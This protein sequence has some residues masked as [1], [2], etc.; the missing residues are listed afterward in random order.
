[1]DE[2]RTYLYKWYDRFDL[3]SKDY[4]F[5]QTAGLKIPNPSALSRLANEVNFGGIFDHSADD[6]TPAYLS[7]EAARLVV[8]AQ[9]FA[10]G[11]GKSASA[12]IG[13]EKIEPPYSADAILLRGLTI[14]LTGSSLLDTLL[15]NLC[16]DDPREDDLPAWEL[17]APHKLR[18][19]Q[20]NGKRMSISARGIIDRYTWQSRLMRIL[21][22]QEESKVFVKEVFFTQG[23]EADKSPHDPMKAYTRSEKEGFVP[24]SLSMF[25]ASW[26]DAHSILST[27]KNEI[28]RPAAFNFVAE[29]LYEGIL[30]SDATYTVNAVGLATAPNKAGKFILW[31]HDRFTTPAVLLKNQ[32]LVERLGELL[33]D[34]ERVGSRLWEVTRELCK[35]YLSMGERKTDA[36]A[37]TNLS[38]EIDPRRDYWSKMEGHFHTLLRELPKDKDAAGKQWN[39]AIVREAR[40]AFNKSASQLGQ[41]GRA[42]R[43]RAKVMATFDL[44]RTKSDK[45]RSTKSEEA[46]NDRD[47]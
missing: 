15:I 28:L 42:I 29:L 36:D 30:E 11:F 39:E 14:W 10:L 3:F 26:R 12:T 8:A 47:E 16:P 6:G 45:E 37:V 43:A 13:S 21:P 27:N 25:K 31:R 4:P 35:A 1:V 17:D 7:A 20:V 46:S 34:S 9:S 33:G 41:S 44:N 18:D 22:T 23:R 19:K 38:S 2:I 5:Y 24:I 40:V 32:D